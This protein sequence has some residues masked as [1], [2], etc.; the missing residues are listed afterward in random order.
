MIGCLINEAAITHSRSSAVAYTSWLTSVATESSLGTGNTVV[1]EARLTM[2]RD[3]Y[4]IR[5]QQGHGRGEGGDRHRALCSKPLGRRADART[6]GDSVSS[7]SMLSRLRFGV[8]K[9]LRPRELTATAD[10]GEAAA[11]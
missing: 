7:S 4:G 3:P 8:A 2:S 5:C 6:E 10:D 9:G 1:G 11:N